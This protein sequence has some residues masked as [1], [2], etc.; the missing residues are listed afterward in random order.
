MYFDEE[1]WKWRRFGNWLILGSPLTLVL[2]VLSLATFNIDAAAAGLGV[3]GLTERLLIVEVLAWFVALGRHH[4]ACVHEP[5][6][7]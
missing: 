7:L 5:A 4:L 1:E 2:L 3:A 6:R